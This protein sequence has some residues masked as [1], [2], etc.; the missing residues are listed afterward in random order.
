[1]KAQLPHAELH[2]FAHS[3]HM[4]A[5]EEPEAHGAVLLSFLQRVA[6]GAGA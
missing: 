1:M 2:E 4:P 3:S 6:Q 5:Y